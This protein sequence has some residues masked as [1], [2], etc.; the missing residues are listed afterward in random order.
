MIE[1]MLLILLL[2]LGYAFCE[3][4]V[5]AVDKSEKPG[6][7]ATTARKQGG[8]AVDCKRLCRR[9]FDQCLTE[10]MLTAGKMSAKQLQH[11]KQSGAM[12][13]IKKK[14]YQACLKDCA[15]KGGKGPDAL[16]IKKCL[17]LKSCSA[18]A[19]CIKKHL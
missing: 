11:V 12:S 17:G 1:K 7:P 13:Q 10:I 3:F 6:T 19:Q 14:G 4:G 16:K 15:K 2:G 8:S 5:V 18:Y 9:T